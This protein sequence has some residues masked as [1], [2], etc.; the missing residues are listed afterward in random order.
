MNKGNSM[1][2]KIGKIGLFCASAFACAPFLNAD[3]ADLR[4]DFENPPAQSRAETWYH[5]TSN[6]ATKEGITA[7]IEAMRDMGYSAAHV[8]AIGGYATVPVDGVKIASPEWFDLMKHLGKEAKRCGIA[9]GMH[10]CPGWSSSGGPWIKPE[11]S[12]KAVVG[13]ATYVDAP[14]KGRLKLPQPA[15]KLGFYRDIAVI[16]LPSGGEA[17]K[18]TVSGD[19]SG[20]E[21]ILKGEPVAIPTRNKDGSGTFVFKFEKPFAAK[22]ANLVFKGNH[23]YIGADIYV[24]KDGKEYKRV[25]SGKISSFCDLGSPHYIALKDAGEISYCKV[26]LYN[27]GFP[28]WFS[29]RDM[30]LHRVEFLSDPMLADSA[31][32]LSMGKP[33]AYW[34]PEAGAAN[35]ADRSQMKILT[36]KFANGEVDVDLPA[37]KWKILRIGYTS[38]GAKNQP[39]TCAGLECDKLS[40]R[41]L[42]AH[43]GHYM[44]KMQDA[45]GG[46][47]KYSTIDSY[48]VS[49][50]NWTEGF[51]EEFK[52][53]RGYDITPWLSV[54]VGCPVGTPGETAK[55]CY[56]IQKTVAELF[57][58]NYYDYFDELCRKHGLISI[59]ETYGGPFDYLRSSRKMAFPATEFWVSKHEPSKAIMSMG[60]VYGK[61]RAGAES[62][63]TMYNEGRWQN[64]PRELKFYGDRGWAAGVSE[65]VIHSYVHQ[66]YNA[67]PGFSLGKHGSHLN[68]L[69]TWWKMG[70]PWSDYIARAQVLLQRGRLVADVLFLPPESAPNT[71]FYGGGSLYAKLA[72]TGYV[73][74]I[75]SI[76]DLPDLMFAE[77]GRVKVDKN[78]SSYGLLAID[79][80]RYM[81]LGNLRALEK[82]IRDGANVSAK[83]PIASP[84]LS[85]NADEF[86]AT[87]R[88]IWGDSN[89]PVRKLGKGVLYTGGNFLKALKLTGEKPACLARNSDVIAREDGGT[90]IFYIR[91]NSV[92]KENK[93]VKF[94]VPEGKIPQIWNAVSG[95]IANAPVWKRDGEYVCV[96]LEFDAHDSKFVVFADGAAASFAS[97]DSDFK[98]GDG[99]EIKV[100]E[101]VYGSRKTGQ[102]KDVSAVVSKNLEKGV[103]VSNATF[104]G[105]PAPMKPKTLYVKYSVGGKVRELEVSENQTASASPDGTANTKGVRPVSVDGKLC[106]KF[107]VNATAFGTLSDGS[108]FEVSARDIP[109]ALDVSDDW[110][111][112]FQKNRGA[113]DYITL[114]KLQSLSESEIDCVK[115]FSGEMQYTKTVSVPRAFFGKNRRILLSFEDVYNVAQV[116]VNGEK[117][118]T[119]WT[120]PFEC[121]ITKFVKNGENK[122]KVVVANLWVN[123]IIGDQKFPKEGYPKWVLENRS[124]SETN[125][126]TFSHWEDSWAKDSP[127]KKSGLVGVAEIRA[128]DI[129]PVR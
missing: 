27:A 52:K 17:P 50:Q 67:G 70:R 44:A 61:A 97:F 101:A 68:R 7:D 34:T 114:K 22:T 57:A 108:K 71:Y 39:T 102:L 95:E 54:M 28:D 59:G 12:M 43:W 76:F 63:T 47:L 80:S 118:D 38:T 73:G 116:F 20:C 19:I 75:C 104:G 36:D 15:S 90:H 72:G 79:D 33:F 77:N 83:K 32:K 110:N 4:R 112:A 29:A 120:P 85:D 91:S 42:D 96:P 55:F 46:M 26:V 128:A 2:G 62:F 86:D 58:E 82:L 3:V 18:M 92:S 117:V 31:V 106:V 98:R 127:L 49:G 8:F 123:R 113:P 5:F 107:D 30:Y 14:F 115:Y 119:L 66:P 78:G 23:L 88:R 56:D 13:S 40:K 69:N 11:D 87:V 125:R 25:H 10:N 48:E 51:A 124:V 121:D 21:K 93:N 41:G 81:S 1:M 126:F 35:G 99:G 60:N 37:G 45:F 16:A 24:S 100:L 64:D 74:N 65:F 129:L 103:F 84:T 105:D 109:Q 53:R 89:E 94:L 111:V 9:L 6:V 122:I